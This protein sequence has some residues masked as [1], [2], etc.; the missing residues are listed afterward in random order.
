MNKDSKKNT[1]FASL[2]DVRCGNCNK[3]ITKALKYTGISVCGRCGCR[4]FFVD[5][6]Q[7]SEKAFI[8]YYNKMEEK[9][10]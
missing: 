2:S 10:D 6:V 1:I 4:T 7:V 5:F 9:S 8:E 3:L